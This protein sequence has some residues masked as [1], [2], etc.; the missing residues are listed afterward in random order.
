MFKLQRIDPVVLARY[1]QHSRPRIQVTLRT[2]VV[3]S[4]VSRE[5]VVLRAGAW[6]RHRRWIE[7]RDFLRI[8]GIANIEHTN[9]GFKI[10]AYQRRGIIFVIDAAIVT[11]IGEARKASKIWDYRGT[12]GG[13]VDL[14][15]QLRYQYR[16][17]LI[18][19]IEDAR[20]VPRR[21]AHR[22]GVCP[23]RHAIPASTSFINFD[24]IRPSTDLDW[25]SVLCRTS[26]RNDRYAD[27]LQLR[28]GQAMLDIAHI[29][30]DHAVG[31][32][33]PCRICF[34]AAK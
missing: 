21:V 20:H 26:V 10:A 15:P 28:I 16:V 17:L 8:G 34:A 18:P 23:T 25:N 2:A 7:I 32:S 9:A 27:D 6:C 1:I 4:T 19:Q 30:N 22:A 5:L 31:G 13:K 3:R 33:C 12:V 11:A 14:M 24:Q 29:R